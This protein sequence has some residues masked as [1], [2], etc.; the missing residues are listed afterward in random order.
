MGLQIIMG[1]SGSGKTAHMLRE[2]IDNSKGLPDVTG[3]LLYIVPEQF[4]METQKNIV[5]YSNG[6]GSMAIDVLSFD[7]L[8]K[9]VFEEQG[10]NPLT[11]LD[12]TGKCLILR[13]IIED[14]K[15]RLGIF[16]KKAGYPGFIDEMKSV[17]S[18]FYQYGIKAKNLQDIINDEKISKLLKEKLKDIHVILK[19]VF[20]VLGLEINLEYGCLNY[21]GTNQDGTIFSVMMENIFTRNRKILRQ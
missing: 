9:R 10:Y 6:A 8:A 16:A 5:K 15:N 12:D 20:R 4:T 17:I 18:E 14:N 13:K 1:K 7:R 3:R 11:I 21:M 2:M 19:R